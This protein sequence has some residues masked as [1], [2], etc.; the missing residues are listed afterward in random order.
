MTG[1][2]IIRTNPNTH[3]NNDTIVPLP[4]KKRTTNGTQQSTTVNGSLADQV[5]SPTK[6]PVKKNNRPP[7]RIPKPSSTKSSPKSSPI[8]SPKRGIP[9][10]IKQQNHTPHMTNEINSPT[11]S[12][13]SNNETVNNNVITEAW[14][15]AEATRQTTLPDPNNPPPKPPLPT[16]ASP[17]LPRSV[18]HDLSASPTHR[19]ISTVVQEHQHPALPTTTDQQGYSVAG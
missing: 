6:S 18:V 2:K 15:K 1:E 7:S 10:L 5:P 9:V 12:L 3:H 16:Q 8:C 11:E 14:I 19:P 4:A 13:G 17:M